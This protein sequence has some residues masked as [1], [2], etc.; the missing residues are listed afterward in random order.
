MLKNY[1]W[2]SSK[3][4]LDYKC[5]NMIFGAILNVKI[6]FECHNTI[7]CLKLDVKIGF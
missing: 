1:I 4:K 7:F 2:P 3:V 6:G 5:Q